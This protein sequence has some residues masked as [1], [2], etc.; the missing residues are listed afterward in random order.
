MSYLILYNSGMKN[1]KTNPAVLNPAVLLENLA[2]VHTTPMGVQRIRKNL[3]LDNSIFDVIDFCKKQI[4]SPDCSIKRQGKNWYCEKDGMCITVNAYSYTII[5]AHKVVSTGST[6]GTT[7]LI[8]SCIA[9][10][11]PPFSQ[12]KTYEE[13]SRHYWYREELQSI[14]KSLNVDASGMK[15]ELNHNIEQYL[16]KI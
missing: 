6:T 7:K 15:A 2:K 13:F 12:I 16:R 4:E 10:P 5:T 9:T 3:S 11:R 14:C 1:N 8:T